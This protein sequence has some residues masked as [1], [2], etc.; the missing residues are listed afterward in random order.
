MRE[1]AHAS[2]SDAMAPSET[3]LDPA[4][5]PAKLPERDEAPSMMSG[6]ATVDDVGAPHAILDD[7][8][9]RTPQSPGEIFRVFTRLALQG[10]GGV[11]PIAQRQAREHAEDL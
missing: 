10:F 6:A 9:P 7:V 5:E 4:A 11:L 8:S 2:L 1:Y 3:T